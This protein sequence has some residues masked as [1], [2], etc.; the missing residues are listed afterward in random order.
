MSTN[1]DNLDWVDGQKSIPG[2][3]PDLYFIPKSDIVTW[4]A[5]PAAPASAADE[6]TYAGDFVLAA[7]A[8]WKKINCIDVK[9][10]PQSEPQGEV[11]CKSFNNKMT[12]VVS[13]TEEKA[14]AFAKLA[15]NTDLVYI[16]R[17]K[18]SGKWRVVGCEM[19]SSET[20]ATL[21]IGSTPTGDRGVTIEVSASDYI[22]FP[23][24]D[25]SIVGDDGDVNPST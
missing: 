11:R 23:F 24:Y 15:N 12:I 20:K 14:T 1:F 19:F 21:N 5:L 10:Q 17:E 7:L 2:I 13:L 16:Y 3:Y 9:S 25:G 22:P 18:D 6:V 8:T 4:P